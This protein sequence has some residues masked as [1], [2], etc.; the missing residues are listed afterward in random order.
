M[1]DTEELTDIPPI[2]PSRDDVDTYQ[3]SRRG[4]SREIVRPT[5]AKQKVST[6]PVR[7]ML[8]VLTC[9]VL[10]AGAADVLFLW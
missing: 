1:R 7:I 3:Q 2:V 6:W 8:T 5:M 4:Q 10:G 9:A